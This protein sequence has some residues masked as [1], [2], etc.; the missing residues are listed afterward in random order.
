[1]ARGNENHIVIFYLSWRCISPPILDFT[2]RFDS[3][4]CHGSFSRSSYTST[5]VATQ[6]GAWL[7][8][9]LGGGGVEGGGGVSAGIGYS[10]ISIL[11]LGEIE[12]LVQCGSRCSCLSR[13]VPEIHVQQQQATNNFDFVTKRKMSPKTT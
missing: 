5:P 13:S 12:L 4:F 8:F 6:P 2:I 9:L 1:M 10:G 7:F 11:R 3:L